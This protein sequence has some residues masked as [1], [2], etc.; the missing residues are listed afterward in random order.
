MPSLPLE[1]QDAD[2]H[3]RQ[4]MIKRGNKS[5]LPW[6]AIVL[7]GAAAAAGSLPLHAATPAAAD[8]QAAG[9][10]QATVESKTRLIKLL[11]SQSPAMQRIPQSNNAQAKKKLADAQALFAKASAEAN[12]GRL[13]PAVKMLD[14]TLREITA[15]SRMVPDTSQLASQERSRYTS[16]SEA[17]RAFLNLHKN[18]SARMAARNISGS[19]D[20]LDTILRVKGQAEKAESLAAAGNYKDANG[21]LNDAYKSIVAALN[22]MLM[23]ETIVY[24]LKFDSPADELKH[25]LAR[26][27]SYEELIPLAIEQL[28]PSRETALMSQRYMQQSKDLRDTA[29][30]QAAS[31]EYQAALK[32]IQEATGHLQ[33]A[34]RVAGVVVPQSTESKP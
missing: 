25:E 34:L 13:E 12:A 28:N 32:T 26:N 17:T 29:Q 20:S 21:I 23:A 24:D 18:L 4:A 27:R 30:K 15:A 8:T 11:L 2:S 10:L 16:L 5:G 31:G 9:S 1:E 6:A 19:S 33:R 14:E 7:A 3:S 22:K